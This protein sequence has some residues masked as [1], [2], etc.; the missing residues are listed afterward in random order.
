M[1]CIC[2]RAR[3]QLM[4]AGRWNRTQ[5]SR[6][7]PLFPNIRPR[8]QVRARAPCYAVQRL[9]EQTSQRTSELTRK[10]RRASPSP[11]S[12]PKE[13]HRSRTRRESEYDDDGQGKEAT[14]P[15]R[16]AQSMP[17]PERSPA[18]SK[19]EGSTSKRA[20]ERLQWNDLDDSITEEKGSSTDDG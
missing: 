15:R 7:H 2:L 8:A 11:R 14:A 20:R 10:D 19:S 4:Q 12:F 16:E 13:R 9:S 5:L 18:T 6:R 1:P 3:T 17:S